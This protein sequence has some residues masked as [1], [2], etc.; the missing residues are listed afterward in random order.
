M[1]PMDSVGRPVPRV[2]GLGKTTGETRYMSDL[3]FPGMVWGR[4][5]R[6]KY[7]RAR[8][9]SINTEAAEKSRGVHCVLTHKHVPGLNGFGIVEPDQP[10]LCWDKVRYVGDAVALVVADTEQQATEA[11]ERIAVDYEPLPPVLDPETALNPDTPQVHERGNLLLRNRIGKGDIK[12]GFAESEVVVEGRY[13]TQ[14]FEHAFLEPEGGVG[15][16]D[17]KTGVLDIYCGSQYPFRDQLQIARAMGIEQSLINVHASPVGG[18]FGG[19]D[20]ITIQ[21]LLAM[22]AYYAK[23]PVKLVLTREESF[24]SHVKRHPMRLDC[25]VGA[26]SDGKLKALW[27][28]ILSD[29]GAYSSLSGPVLN[30]SLEGGA[31]PYRIEQTELNGTAVFTNNGNCGAYRGFGTTQSCFAMEITLDKL[32]ER[33][34]MDPIEL[35]LH[36]VLRRGDLTAFDTKLFTS[37]GIEETL[38]IARDSDLWKKRHQRKA[39]FEHPYY[40]GVGVASEMQAFGLGKG[41]PDFAGAYVDLQKDGRLLVRQGAIEMGQGLLTVLVQMAAEILQCDVGRIDITQG[42]TSLGPD[43]GSATA[44]K[45]TYLIGNAVCLAARDFIKHVEV[46]ARENLGEDFVYSKGSLTR[47]GS[48]I[49][50]SELARLAGE[51]NKLIR[52]EGHFVHPVDQKEFGDGLPHCL[53]GFITEMASVVVDVETGEIKV[54]EMLVIPDCGRAINPQAIEGQAEG[55]AVMGMAYALFEKVL[56]DK[57]YFKN[58]AFSTYILPTSM[59]IPKKIET[60]I[61]ESFEKTNYFGAK[62]VGELPTV[63][64]CPAIVNAVYDAVGVRYDQIPLFP[65]FVLDGLENAYPGRG[66]PAGAKRAPAGV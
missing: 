45:T 4:V 26:T 11:M 51:K 32:A 34:G 57:G 30:L 16:Y 14:M 58:N 13:H 8:I 49:S 10:V 52:G 21:I 25:K 7:P 50:L 43:S 27:F 61:V 33:I 64:I 20:E 12:K 3:N 48:S 41:I 60:R 55:G 18:G 46:F 54:E 42:D 17:E 37:V 24:I 63:P 66:Y 1:Q 39:D 19:K 5:L 40:Y 15:I 28:D 38:L 22:M 9:K 44:S 59:D 6:A 53:Y 23:R 35:R 62:G 36:N 47:D 31:G 29:A 56:L 65:E 2:D